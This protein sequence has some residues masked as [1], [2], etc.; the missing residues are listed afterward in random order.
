MKPIIIGLDIGTTKL[1]AVAIDAERGTLLAV[2]SIPNAGH[3]AAGPDG[4][5]QD[6]R[7]VI[8]GALELLA[9]LLAR[10]E[11][12][13]GQV[14]GLGVSGQMHGVVVVDDACVPLTHLISWQD[15]R[16]AHPFG[17]SGRSYTEEVVYRLGDHAPG[18]TGC[19][20]A[21]G[22]GAV[23]LFRLQQQGLLPARGTALTIH[24]AMVMTLCGRA[25]TDPT[26][27]ASWGI[28]DGVSGGWLADVD[29]MFPGLSPLLP[30]IA[31]IGSRAG[32]LAPAVAAR[33][34]LPAGIPVAVALGDN[35]ASFLGSVPSPAASVLINLG[36][37]GQMSTS[38]E[39]FVYQAP[40]ETRPFVDG[41]WLMVGASL[42][43]GRAYQV[44][45]SFYRKIAHDLFDLPLTDSL[46]QRMNALAE[47]ASDDC[48]GLAVSTLFEG[49]RLHP[50][51]RGTI[52]G[53]SA[54]NLTPA[55]LTS[56]VS[57]GMADELLGFF[58]IARQA[59]ARPTTLC[60]AGNGVRHNPIVRRQL[61]QQ[62][63]LPLTLPA[64]P[65]EAAVGAALS[66]G[67]AAGVFANWEEATRRVFAGSEEIV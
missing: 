55:N 32:V 11:V 49:S 40:L 54:R 50:A 60:G 56:A 46:Y 3:V 22:Y 41:R 34:G 36:T 24:D 4:A 19:E 18:R 1:G 44:L 6:A 7:V 67:V 33:T 14:C 28:F 31:P 48:G 8:A 38:I 21:T 20:P 2:E 45:E 64:H 61:T 35:Q 65:E 57:H 66:G 23:T 43:G 63:G 10:P 29:T 62:L 39:R 30:A 9:T 42:C 16:G 52:S 53:I 15:G 25:L 13:G 47:Q 59:G 37:G 17:S 58:A 12:Q 51:Q 27:A 26:G 5:E